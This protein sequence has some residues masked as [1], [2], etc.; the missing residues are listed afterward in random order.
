[1]F[2]VGGQTE[3]DF[4]SVFPIAPVPDVQGGPR[5]VGKNGGLNVF[6]GCAGQGIYRGDR[7]PEE[8]YGDLFI[9]EPGPCIQRER[10]YPFLQVRRED[11]PWELHVAVHPANFVNPSKPI[12]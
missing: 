3:A 4:R 7:L 10:S 8:M 12:S 1:M 5:R 11:T 9:P 6:T 2:D